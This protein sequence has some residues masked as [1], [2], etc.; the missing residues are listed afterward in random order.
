MTIKFALEITFQ[1]ESFSVIYV[2]VLIFE[3]ACFVPLYLF[4]GGVSLIQLF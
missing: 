3:R 1:L 4:V 2:Q